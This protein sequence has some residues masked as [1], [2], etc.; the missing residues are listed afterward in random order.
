M[1]E[2]WISHKDTYLFATL[3]VRRESD[4]IT[5]RARV[6]ALGERLGFNPSQREAMRLACSE[7][8]SNIIK[9]AEGQG[10]LQIWLQPGPTLDLF[11]LDRG[12]GIPDPERAR[13][14]GFT[15]AGT[16][17]KGLG[18]IIRAGDE[19]DLYTLTTGQ[20]RGGSHGSAVLVR[21]TQRQLPRIGLYTRSRGDH[22]YNGDRIFIRPGRSELSWLHADGL[23]SGERAQGTTTPMLEALVNETDPQAILTATAK[24]LNSE[25][26]AVALAGRLEFSSRE[27]TIAGVGDVHAHTIDI[28]AGVYARHGLS[29]AAGV[30]GLHTVAPRHHTVRLS[31]Q[32][33][34]VTASDG[35]RK[36]WSIADFPGLYERH[37]QLVA[38]W[39]GNRLGRLA[40]DQ[41]LAVIAANPAREATASE[42]LPAGRTT[43]PTEEDPYASL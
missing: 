15:T 36:D 12:P 3:S 41:S 23:G 39:L 9:H 2:I 37:P 8:T 26:G 1:T 13:R 27:V 14:D 35:I 34:L 20:S 4:R 42:G 38:Y 30:L 43:V 16:L 10:E 31:A 18:S 40:D 29:M 19:G 32:G 24:H 7:L 33:L 28:E 5:A 6:A 11:A 21:F 25:H 22:R 17:G